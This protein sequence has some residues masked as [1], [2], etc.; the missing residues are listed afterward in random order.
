V[1]DAT[2]AYL[3]SEAPHPTQDSLDALLD[4][5][6]TVRIFQGGSAGNSLLEGTLLRQ[7]SDRE[8]L[9]GLRKALQIL[10]GPGGHCMCHGG[11]TLEM[12]SIGVH[13]GQALR[14]EEW[15]DDARLVDGRSLVDWF[16]DHGVPGPQAE[17]EAQEKR[18]RERQL[19]WNQWVEAMPDFLRELPEELWQGINTGLDLEPILAA[20]Q[21]A[22]PDTE[23]RILAI[24]EWYGSG[25]GT[26]TGYPSWEGFAESLLRTFSADEL[27]RACEEALLSDRQTEGAAR[28]FTG[29]GFLAGG[30]PADEALSIW[31][32]PF[33]VFVGRRTGPTAPLPSSLKEQLW[34]HCERSSD[35]DKRQRA[36]SAFE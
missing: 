2:V 34:R 17:Y 13:H 10:D 5:V 4:R 14:W 7:I 16:A 18:E 21:R 1:D 19:A 36:S 28:F 33:D 9:N 23:K 6:Q 12:V 31:Y 24:F 8:D 22:C 26:W 35:P 20:A 11:P 29:K 3:E 25:I 15:K 30:L 27:I 32:G